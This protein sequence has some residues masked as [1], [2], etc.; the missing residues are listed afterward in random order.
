[1]ADHI[2]KDSAWGSINVHEVGNGTNVVV[3]TPIGTFV[4]EG[5]KHGLTQD[6][7][8][9][10]DD[11]VYHATVDCG[12][13]IRV[14]ASTLQFATSGLPVYWTGTAFTATA[15]TNQLVGYVDRAKPSATAGPLFIQLVPTAI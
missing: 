4:T 7:P 5:A 12:A 9:L 3:G 2:V 8:Y 10:G 13:L 15:S 14:D 6:T 11:G 1:M